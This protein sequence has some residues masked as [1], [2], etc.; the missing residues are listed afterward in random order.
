MNL[1]QEEAMVVVLVRELADRDVR[2]LARAPL[3]IVGEGT[4]D[5]RRNVVV[6]Q[7]V[8]RGSSPL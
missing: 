6:G 1:S 4:S 3:M 8:K 7:M 2:P 5:I